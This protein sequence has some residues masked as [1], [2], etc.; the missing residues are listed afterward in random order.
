MPLALF[1]KHAEREASWFFR[2]LGGRV[3][4]GGDPAACA[5]AERISAWLRAIP[6]FH[7]GVLALRYVPRS[8]PKPIAEEF[9]EL[10]SVVV[11]L[12]CALHPAIGTSTEALEQ[13]SVERLGEVIARCER[14]R[15]RR[16]STGRTRPRCRAERELLRLARRAH[17]HVELAHRA[18]TRVRGFKTCCVPTPLP[19]LGATWTPK[20]PSTPVAVV[21]GAR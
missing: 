14:I 1:Q 7:R 17:K 3:P 12:E 8:W 6:A 15:A 16:P 19:V 18:F 11:R 9:G 2:E 4:D 13:A 5:A 21:R 10:A 20:T